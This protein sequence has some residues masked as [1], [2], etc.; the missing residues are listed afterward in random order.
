MT[1]NPP[2]EHDAIQP[3]RDPEPR[4]ARDT[5]EVYAIPRTLAQATLDYLASR[6]YRDVFALV[7]AFESL[8]PLSPVSI[9]ETPD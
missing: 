9:D 5:A 4:R 6:P 3:D 1:G 7:Q 8:E 2:G